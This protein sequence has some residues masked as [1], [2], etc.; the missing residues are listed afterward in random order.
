MGKLYQWMRRLQQFLGGEESEVKQE[1]QQSIEQKG[2]TYGRVKSEKRKSESRVIYQYPKSGQFRFPLIEDGPVRR[3]PKEE[4][5]LIQTSRVKRKEEKKRPQ[6]QETPKAAKPEFKRTSIP[7]P[8]YGFGDRE[9]TKSIMGDHISVRP[10]E[11]KESQH[12]AQSDLLEKVLERASEETVEPSAP[13]PI[14]TPE[15]LRT[16]HLLK[17]HYYTEVHNPSIENKLLEKN[18]V[19]KDENKQVVAPLQ[20]DSI[21]KLV[22]SRYFE[23]EQEL[24]RGEEKKAD[25]H[26]QSSLNEPFKPILTQPEAE[27]NES[28]EQ[29][30]STVE[31]QEE[32]LEEPEEKIGQVSDDTL[33]SP[34][35]WGNA[36]TK[37]RS[38]TVEIFGEIN[39]K[40]E[41]TTQSQ[42]M[43]PSTEVPAF[44][45]DSSINQED[46]TKE[47]E[48]KVEEIKETEKRVEINKPK[49]PAI[50]F[51]VMMLPQDKK[52]KQRVEP[53]PEKEISE[54]NYAYPSIQLLN[55]PE[56]QA[57]DDSD[58]L[59]EQGDILEETLQSF[60]V[61]AKVVHST[62]GP[63][64]TRFEV[65][66]GRGVKVNKITG[67]T[68]DM[69]LSLICKRYS[70]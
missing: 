62:K 48:E 18:I 53:K 7:S 43:E 37:Q 19:E 17:T 15:D 47:R 70:N 26:V 4:K 33:D 12:N 13:D 2:Y 40:A 23:E 34:E 41:E 63:S 61:D 49:K 68:D 67:L 22:E 35:N 14:Q 44:E 59:K 29:V 32:V 56:V 51:N 1:I 58:W 5:P 6:K 21:S 69:K 60:H 57:E 10:F 54:T 52:P 66:P 36:P 55:Y 39:E 9:T 42:A 31:T 25:E 24:E 11:K 8:V 30:S 28:L 27:V 50:P 64:V 38:S 45:M 65:Q 16:D 46:S 3:Q 20:I